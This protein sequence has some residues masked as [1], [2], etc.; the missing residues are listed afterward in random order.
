M[1]RSGICV[2]AVGHVVI[3]YRI[4]E[5][6][7]PP[8]VVSVSRLWLRLLTLRVAAGSEQRHGG[9]EAGPGV[10]ANQR[11]EGIFSPTLRPAPDPSATGAALR[12]NLCEVQ[13]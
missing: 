8:D 9:Q 5:S 6:N 3:K 12:V 2:S 10:I 13:S 4:T 11:P 7:L 1:K